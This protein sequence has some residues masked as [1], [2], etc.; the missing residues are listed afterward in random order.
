MS[1]RFEEVSFSYPGTQ[2]LVLENLSFDI[3]AGERCALVGLNG[4]GKT[5]LVKL[6]LGLYQPKSGRILI[7][8]VD[9][10]TLSQDTLFS[11]FGAVFQEVE[12]LALT[13]AETVAAS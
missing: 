10:A 12:P 13:V 11:L 9:A 1:V 2:R 4:A 3:K 8:G 7:N 5:T 6:L